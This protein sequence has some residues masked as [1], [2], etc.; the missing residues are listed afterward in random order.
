MLDRP[1]EKVATIKA[2]RAI[3]E[4]HKISSTFPRGLQLH[5]RT[6]YLPGCK[7][8]LYLNIAWLGRIILAVSIISIPIVAFI[9]VY[10]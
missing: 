7:L 1:T 5:V 2:D 3:Y 8:M 9:A 6:T 4:F 10:W